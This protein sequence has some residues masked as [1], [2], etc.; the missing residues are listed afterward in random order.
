MAW[1]NFAHTIIYSESSFFLRIYAIFLSLSMNMQTLVKRKNS[2]F[3]QLVGMTVAWYYKSSNSR[4]P[5]SSALAFQLFRCR[6]SHR[7]RRQ[8]KGACFG[9]HLFDPLSWVHNSFSYSRSL[10]YISLFFR[11]TI[12]GNFSR[13]RDNSRVSIEYLLISRWEEYEIIY[14]FGRSKS[15]AKSWSSDASSCLHC[16]IWNISVTRREKSRS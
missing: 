8:I 14:G 9:N 2:F 15:R 5:S 13:R 6:R 7:N 16:S 1:S 3:L 4:N 10:I 11:Q 12:E